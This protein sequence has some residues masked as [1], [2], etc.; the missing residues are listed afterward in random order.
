MI[1]S[2]SPDPESTRPAG[3]FA[4]LTVLELGGGI[5]GAMVAMLLADHGADVIK[6]EPPGGASTF[7]YAS[8]P[9]WDRGKRSVTLDP[10]LEDHGDRLRLLARTA[11]VL[12][13]GYGPGAAPLGL[14]HRTLMDAN[15]R[16]VYCS[17]SAYGSHTE[18]GDRPAVDA[19]VAARMGLHWEQRGYYG[20]QPAHIAGTAAT[21]SN[22]TVP[23]GAEQTGHREGP[24]FLAL[25][26]PSIGAAL[27]ALVG[28]S[29]ALRA[30]LLTGRGQLVETSLLQGGLLSTVATWQR[31]PD[32]ATA[33]YRLPYFDRRHPKGLFQC[34][35][36]NSAA[37]VGGPSAVAFVQ[38]AASGPGA[39]ISPARRG[40]GDFDLRRL[41]RATR[42]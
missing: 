8:R 1:I 37:P 41:R 23:D 18:Y 25:P 24:I 31:V 38:A 34:S 3:V 27:L 20:G 19:L 42:R 10:A 32:P 11:D 35:D 30:R 16:L 12:I 15:P 5:A 13:E 2:V 40:I 22:L 7:P 9:V 28:I 17:L 6:V 33:G 14:G 21:T 26:W 36:V 4:G 39:E 29:A